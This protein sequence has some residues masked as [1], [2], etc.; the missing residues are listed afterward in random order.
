M[1][2]GEYRDILRKIVVNVL[3][4]RFPGLNRK[5]RDEA[6]NLIAINIHARMYG[7]NVNGV[8][9]ALWRKEEPTVTAKE[10]LETTKC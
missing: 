1:L 3:N 10:I 6:A 4:K 7:A 9:S 8:E 2:A 5:A